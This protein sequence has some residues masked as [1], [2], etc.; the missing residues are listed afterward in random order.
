MRVTV[1]CEYNASMS[2]PEGV[3]AYPEGLGNYLKSVYESFGHETTLITY[4]DKRH[5]EE[6]T[7]E[8]LDNTDVLV[9]WGHWYH[10]HIPDETAAMVVDK[11]QKGMGFMVLH[12]GHHCKPFRRLMGTPCNLIWREMNERERVWVIDDTHPIANGLGT[13][14]EI[15][16]EEMY[17]ERFD[18]PTPD[19]L[20]FISWFQGGEV[21]RSGCVWKRGRGKVFFLRC[22]HET[23][24]TYRQK[25]VQLVMKNAIEYLKPVVRIESYGSDH[26][27]N[28]PEGEVIIKD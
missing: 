25:E 11:V 12:S 6:L 19:E 27:P 13:Y 24:P 1:V 7:S 2:E 9:W 17:G 10:Q 21:M 16:H 20:V 8:L 4:D 22:G 3:K 26:R 18:I 15:P 14:F 23:N 5:A 28:A